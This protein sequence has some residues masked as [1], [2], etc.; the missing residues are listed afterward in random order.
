MAPSGAFFL[1]QYGNITLP[2]LGKAFGSV[3]QVVVQHQPPLV[4]V[5]NS[6]ASE[7]PVLPIPTATW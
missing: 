1:T 4:Y 2:L 7:Q 3:L 5:D 6:K